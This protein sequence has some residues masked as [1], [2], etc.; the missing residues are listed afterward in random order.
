MTEFTAENALI[1]S[2]LLAFF[3]MTDKNNNNLI[4]DIKDNKLIIN[5]TNL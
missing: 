5:T 3:P 4:E 1:T 2:M